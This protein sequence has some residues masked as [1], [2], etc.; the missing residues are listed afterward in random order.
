M[1]LSSCINKSSSESP[2]NSRVLITTGK[3]IVCVFASSSF[4]FTTQLFML[5]NYLSTVLGE[6]K[7]GNSLAGHMAGRG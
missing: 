4:T 5:Y 2:H 3:D 7:T 1:K 6:G